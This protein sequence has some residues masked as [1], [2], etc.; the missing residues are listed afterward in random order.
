MQ[1]VFGRI[2]I[3]LRWALLYNVLAIP[4]AAGALFP[5][6][7]TVLPPQYAGLCMAL[8]SVSVVASSLMLRCYRRPALCNSTFPS[9]SSSSSSDKAAGRG[10]GAVQQEGAGS[11]RDAPPSTFTTAISR[12]RR[13][14]ELLLLPLM[15]IVSLSPPPPS[16]RR[17][18]AD[19]LTD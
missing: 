17:W 7:H 15:F 19:W 5:W 11:K 3:N 2:K 18:L 8:S 14:A 13:W 10:S 12:A 6:L 9:A 4:V 16:L 1:V